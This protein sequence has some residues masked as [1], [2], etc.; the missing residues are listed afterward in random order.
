MNINRLISNIKKES[1]LD[2]FLVTSYTDHDIYDII[3]DVAL[4]DYERMFK[5]EVEAGIISLTGNR[6]GPD[7][8]LLPDWM[9]RR[10]EASDLK[11]EGVH[12][13]RF[14]NQFIDRSGIGQLMGHRLASMTMESAYTGIYEMQR[15]GS[16]DLFMNY[17]NSCHYEKPN[18]LR[19][20]WNNT[21]PD[22]MGIELSLRTT[23]APNLIGVEQGREYAFYNLAKYTVMWIIYQN[24]GKYLESSIQD[25]DIK[26]EEW[27]TAGEKRQELLQQMYSQ[28]IRDQ[29]EVKV[30]GD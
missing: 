15:F 27:Q 21:L 13:I 6:I 1:G 3:I 19:F 16:S 2:R 22:G 5:A 8:I 17:L 20:I 23:I 18:R 24:E 10:V 9:V 29:N 25:L 28:S 30:L 11:I 4:K 14:T 26:I 7:V 12:S